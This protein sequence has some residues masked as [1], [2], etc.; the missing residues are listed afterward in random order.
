MTKRTKEKLQT[1]LNKLVDIHRESKPK[2]SMF[3]FFSDS[4]DL[5]EAKGA[6]LTELQNVLNGDSSVRDVVAP[7]IALV[8][9]RYNSTDAKHA[10]Q[11]YSAI[12]FDFRDSE[13]SLIKKVMLELVEGGA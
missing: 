8:G 2:Q 1:E 5:Y 3:D 11:A 9:A 12:L 10:A 6:L 13:S 4:K 7:A